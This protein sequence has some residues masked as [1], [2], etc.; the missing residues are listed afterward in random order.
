MTAPVWEDPRVARGLAR[1]REARD[2]AHASGAGRLGWKTGLGGAAAEQLGTTGPLVGYLT[3]ATLLPDDATIDVAGWT[4]PV[5]EPEIA[6]K[7]G[8]DLPPGST[9]EEALASID[10]L[11]S[12]IEV[13]DVDLPLEDPEAILARSFFHR[14]VVLGTFDR[15]RAGADVEGISLSVRGPDGVHADHVDPLIPIGD[16]GEIACYVA[17]V[18]AQIGEILA[19]DDIVI[20]GSGIPAVPLAAGGRIEVVHHGLGMTSVIVA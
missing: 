2:A 16:L 5:L 1:M 6:I 20:T 9:R 3:R 19:A 15:S 18:V 14:G 13:A 11:A 10:S 12:A 8:R 7:M 4:N 17:N